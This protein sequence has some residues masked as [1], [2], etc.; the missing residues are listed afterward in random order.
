MFEN[1][2]KVNQRTGTVICEIIQWSLVRTFA[3][4][5]HYNFDLSF[6]MGAVGVQWHALGPVISNTRVRFHRGCLLNSICFDFDR[7]HYFQAS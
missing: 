5:S 6:L 7:F 1:L 4:F 3:R 2:T